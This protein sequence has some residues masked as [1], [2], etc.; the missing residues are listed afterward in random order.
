MYKIGEANPYK[1][2]IRMKLGI[3]NVIVEIGN[4]TTEYNKP[5]LDLNFK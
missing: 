5:R 1:I 2:E 3:M 4:F